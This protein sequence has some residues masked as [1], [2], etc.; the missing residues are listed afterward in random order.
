MRDTVMTHAD[1][2]SSLARLRTSGGIPDMIRDS[3]FARDS[4][5]MFVAAVDAA[6]R[7]RADLRGLGALHAEASAALADGIG[8]VRVRNAADPDRRWRVA[9]AH[10]RAAAECLTQLGADLS[11]AGRG[12]SAASGARRGSMMA[13][14]AA[15]AES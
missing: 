3:A 7:S 8:L 5:A 12:G 1:T 13:G 6:A 2:L 4:V 14:A 9:E 10:L 11:R 15:A